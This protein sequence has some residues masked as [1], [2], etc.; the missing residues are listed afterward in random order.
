ME[1]GRV[2]NPN[3]NA[4]EDERIEFRYFLGPTFCPW[5]PKAVR[6]RQTIFNSLAKSFGKTSKRRDSSLIDFNNETTSSFKRTHKSNEKKLFS[7][8]ISKKAII[9]E[10]SKNPIS[11][12]IPKKSIINETSKNI[13]APNKNKEETH[14]ILNSNLENYRLDSN[15]GPKILNSTAPNVTKFI[16]PDSHNDSTNIPNNSK[17]NENFNPKIIPE[18][19]RGSHENKHK[20]KCI[21]TICTQMA[22]CNDKKDIQ[23]QV[24]A[25]W[26]SARAVIKVDKLVNAEILEPYTEQNHHQYLVYSYQWCE[27]LLVLTQRGLFAFTKSSTQANKDIIVQVKNDFGH[28]KEKNVVSLTDNNASK[29]HRGLLDN[30]K[31]VQNYVL[32]IKFP[33]VN[34]QHLWYQELNKWI[35][36]IYSNYK[37]CFLQ[38]PVNSIIRPPI[39]I[40]VDIPE[41]NVSLRIPTAKSFIKGSGKTIIQIE[42]AHR[43]QVSEAYRSKYVTP[44]GLPLSPNPKR[45]SL[46]Q[47]KNVI[48]K[49]S[50]NFRYSEI[51]YSQNNNKPRLDSNAFQI[52][53]NE[54]NDTD[55]EQ[56][57]YISGADSSIRSSKSPSVGTQV[58]SFQRST[59]A[60]SSSRATVWDIRDMALYTLLSIPK[61]AP[62]V[63]KWIESLKTDNLVIGMAWK[64]NDVLEWVTPHGLYPNNRESLGGVPQTGSLENELVYT[65]NFMEKTHHLELRTFKTMDRYK[66]N[67]KLV[68]EPRPVTGFVLSCLKP[69]KHNTSS[70]L[71]RYLISVHGGILV[72]FRTKSIKNN[73]FVFYQGALIESKKCD[74][75]NSKENHQFCNID[76]ANSGLLISNC[77]GM[78]CLWN[79]SSVSK[80]SSSDFVRIKMLTNKFIAIGDLSDQESDESNPED[81]LCY[82][83]VLV[84]R[85]LESMSDNNKLYFRCSSKKVRDFWVNHLRLLSSFW[86]KRANVEKMGRNLTQNSSNQL[87]PRYKNLSYSTKQEY[88]NLWAS[89]ICSYTIKAFGSKEIIHSGFLYKKSG[90]MSSYKRI[91]CVLVHSHLV[92][93]ELPTFKKKVAIES[94]FN[95]IKNMYVSETNNYQNTTNDTQETLSSE[96]SDD[97]E[98]D[99]NVF[100]WLSYFYKRIKTISLESSYVISVPRSVFKGIDADGLPEINYQS[101]IGYYLQKENE[102]YGKSNGKQDD[103]K[104]NVLYKESQFDQSERPILADRFQHDS[105]ISHDNVRRCTFAILTPKKKMK[106]ANSK[107]PSNSSISA[108]SCT[109][110]R[111]FNVNNYF[112]DELDKRVPKPKNS[113][114]FNLTSHAGNINNTGTLGNTTKIKSGGGLNKPSFSS[115]LSKQLSRNSTQNMS[116]ARTFTRSIFGKNV[117]E[118]VQASALN[119]YDL[120]QMLVSTTPFEVAKPLLLK[121]SLVSS[122]S[123]SWSDAYTRNFHKSIDFSNASKQY[124]NNGKESKLVEQNQMEMDRKTDAKILKYSTTSKLSIFLD[125]NGQKINLIDSDNKPK[126]NF[127]EYTQTKK[128]ETS[129]YNISGLKLGIDDSNNVP[130]IS[131]IGDLVKEKLD[132]NSEK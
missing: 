104:F 24:D 132:S 61:Y 26:L 89:S 36:A 111:K 52:K 14:Q 103:S 94:M 9:N 53:P 34:Q 67:K 112:S 28:P 57:L 4:F 18:N 48:P 114:N 29:T 38:T 1:N 12:E 62:I 130:S 25:I 68:S 127:G 55:I 71:A 32:L 123:K 47:K 30:H 60:F 10:T 91:F 8:Q 19:Q 86:S 50:M 65:S 87:I 63:K 6:K 37:F 73:P 59:E 42:K 92:E 121:L 58:T 115:S 81:E 88:E 113:V 85:R 51:Y 98:N 100:T 109:D 126:Q 69:K 74:V 41:I 56:Y 83:F 49:Q 66:I 2:P 84:I 11:I 118:E 3:H 35:L 90:G 72:F 116:L 125:K 101:Y 23:K 17:I 5:K 54:Q 16:F 95:D 44:A 80:P 7:N 21:C 39:Y 15:D 107:L 120:I 31:L 99:E 102:N 128:P 45:M 75:C 43:K 96:Q 119:A 82:W 70:A 97:S 93:F 122:D 22:N 76:T 106:I 79:I 46:T 124:E 117:E 20:G 27:S 105:I 40:K 13:K 110:F 77:H 33:S 108:I 78:V 131:N 64:E 129:L